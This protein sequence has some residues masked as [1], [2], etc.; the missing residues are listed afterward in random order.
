MDSGRM[1]RL[2]TFIAALL[3]VVISVGAYTLYQKRSA[4]EQRLEIQSP[5]PPATAGAARVHIDGAVKNPG[6]YTIS[7]TRSLQDLIGDAGGLTGDAD[8]NNI[9]LNIPSSTEKPQTQR[10]NIN[11]AGSW[12]LET[13]PEVGPATARAII[14]Y[15]TRN[16]PFN[17]TAELLKVKGI[18]PKKLERIKDLITVN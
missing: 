8:T 18:G 7:P 11:T 1:D 15:R 17:N 4:Y 16:G 6:F 12:L 13:L 2:W 14:D 3:L 5:L 9:N 10:I